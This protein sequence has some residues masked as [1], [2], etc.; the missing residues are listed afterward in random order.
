M[1]IYVKIVTFKIDDRLL[2]R[3]DR[4]AEKNGVSRSEVIREAII[5]YLNGGGYK[6]KE[7][8]FKVKYVVL[9]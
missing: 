8:M 1:G 7:R 5:R 6:K 3:V 4:F 2:E 9:T